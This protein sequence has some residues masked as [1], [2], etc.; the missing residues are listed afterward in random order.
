MWTGLPSLSKHKKKGNKMVKNKRDRVLG[1]LMYVLISL[2][3]VLFSW[4]VLLKL[5]YRLMARLGKPMP[6]PAS[7]GWLV[8]NPIRRLYTQRILNRIGLRP[9]ETVLELGPGPSTFTIEAARR[10]GP[11]GRLIVVE[12]QPRIAARV[13]MRAREAGLTNVETYIASAYGL[14][15]PIEDESVDRAFVITVLP[16]IPY[17]TRALDELNRVLR[18]GGLL[19]ITEEFLDPDYAFPF[20][21]VQLVEAAGFS[22]ERFFGNFWLYTL[23]FGKSS[24]IAYD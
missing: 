2:A 12:M 13:E 7:V 21:T 17:Q 11:E 10:V 14:P 22:R 23:N 19:S 24:G 4:L 5:L 6:D 15:M 9:G 20:E 16:E 1:W 18:P 8:D 3:G